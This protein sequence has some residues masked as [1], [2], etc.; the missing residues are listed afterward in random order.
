MLQA[1]VL[2]PSQP[3]T[4]DLVFLEAPG[5]E[6]GAEAEA[7]VQSLA[8]SEARFLGLLRRAK[9]LV[10]HARASAPPV[11]RR[12]KVYRHGHKVMEVML[13]GTGAG[14]IKT[15]EAALVFS[16][17]GAAGAAD[18]CRVLGWKKEKLAYHQFPCTQKLHDVYTYERLLF[19][20]HHRVHWIFEKQVYPGEGEGETVWLSYLQYTHAPNVE[21]AAV[22]PVVRKILGLK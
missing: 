4:V 8:L 1:A 20:V 3:T 11:L 17:Q 9:G 21:V 14:E 13:G 22:E 12:A 5:A 15:Y 7:A 16:A 2:H 19:R 6:A 10:V 18:A